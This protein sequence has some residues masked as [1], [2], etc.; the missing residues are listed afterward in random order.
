MAYG[1]QNEGRL[2]D[3]RER[4]NQVK[5]LLDN[6]HFVDAVEATRDALWGEFVKTKPEDT[7]TLQ[8]ISLQFQL[9]D[10]LIRAL[11]KHVETGEMA[12]AELL[13]GQ[14]SPG[15]QWPATWRSE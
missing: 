11:R 4:G 8:R 7:Q 3:E 1:G 14:Q 2:H 6:Q 9:L 10:Y 15:A 5:Q 13:R 12:A